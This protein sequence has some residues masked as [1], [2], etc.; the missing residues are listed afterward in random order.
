MK[1]PR[2]VLGAVV[3]VV[4]LA[5]GAVVVL[6]AGDSEGG[7]DKP[8]RAQLTLQR[9][10]RPDTGQAELLVSLPEERLN[11]LDTTGGETSVL[12]RCFDQPGAQTLRQQTEWPL[13][14]EVGFPPHIHQPV[15]PQVLDR[16]RGCRLTGNGINFA[17]RVTGRAPSVTQ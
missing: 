5:V 15:P 3:L 9:S 14:E 2:V 6:V 8:V 10:V 13:L 12:L 16:I 4:A 11:T 7:G 1:H 17:G